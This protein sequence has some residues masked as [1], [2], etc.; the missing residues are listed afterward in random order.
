MTNDFWY[1]I[2]WHPND[3]LQASVP[4][5]PSLYISSRDILSSDSEKTLCIKSGYSPNAIVRLSPRSMAKPHHY[6][7]EIID[8]SRK[9][10]LE[11]AG[12][13]F[14]KNYWRGLIIIRM[15]TETIWLMTN[16]LLLGL[17][18]AYLC[19]NVEVLSTQCAP[20]ARSPGETRP[21]SKSSKA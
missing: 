17:I 9:A 18:W 10:S 13:L 8:I 2:Q 20:T 4:A 21:E 7:R 11:Q 6:S 16:N 5:Q 12:C 14:H 1:Q 19:Q 15:Q 3:I